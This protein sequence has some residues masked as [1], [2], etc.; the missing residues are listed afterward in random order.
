[1]QIYVTSLADYNAGRQVGDWVDVG[2]VSEMEAD[3]EKILK[4]SK[5]PNA[6]EWAIHDYSDFPNMGEHASLE[7]I[8]EVGELVDEHGDV[9]LAAISYSPE[10]LD[11]A[12]KLVEDGYMG[13][14]N[15]I[16]DFAYEYLKDTGQLEEMGEFGARYFD[17]S[18][19]GR[20]LAI[21][22]TV[23]DYGGTTYVF[24]PL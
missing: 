1:M 10:D 14:G 4:S 24:Q 20:D 6:E 19:F 5:E 11:Y 17:Y 18:A 2:T 8:E 22:M 21:D 12:K 15:D 7:E 16:E 3:I 9:F 13:Q 23:I